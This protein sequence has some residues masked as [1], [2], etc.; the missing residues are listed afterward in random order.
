M[1]NSEIIRESKSIL[2]GNYGKV[3]F[4]F[5][6]VIIVNNLL[7]SAEVYQN[8]FSISEIE[9]GVISL[10]ITVLITFPLSVGV[11]SY[12]ISITNDLFDSNKLFDGFKI[13]VKSAVAGLI[14]YLVI[15]L[16]FVLLIVPGIYAA[17]TFSQVFY[18]ISQNNDIS[19]KEAFKQSSTMMKGH[20]WQ[21]FKLIIRYVFYFILSVFTLFIW[22]LW[23]IPQMNVSFAIFFREL[24]K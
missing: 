5:L 15:I 16:G 10:A 4:P 19:I 20:K 7:S 18:I 23:L 3:I 1:E 2:R 22:A 14:Y 6:I 12:S 11:A 13:F 9:S 17:L 24:N 8:L 21:L